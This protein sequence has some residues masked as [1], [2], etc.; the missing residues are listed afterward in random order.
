[1]D[2]YWEKTID[3]EGEKHEIKLY[4]YTPKS[5]AM[6]SSGDFGKKFSTHFKELGGKFN[7]KLSIGPGWI[8]RLDLQSG[9]SDILRKIFKGEIKPKELGVKNPMF[10]DSDIDFKI[11]NTL[12][13]LIE[14]LP[15]SEEER[16][17]SENEEVRTIVY[18]NKSDQTTT[19]GECIYSFSSSRKS[20]EIYQLKL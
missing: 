8:F 16:V 13:E 9:L 11:F 6:T 3:V 18:Y 2:P 19:Q 1:M 12:Q 14:L 20:M 4:S 15:E 10:D 17:L 7:P 5:I